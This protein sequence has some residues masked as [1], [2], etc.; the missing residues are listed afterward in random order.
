MT[1]C[2]LDARRGAHGVSPASPEADVTVPLFVDRA[3]LDAGS[4][5]RCLTS[6]LVPDDT[7]RRLAEQALTCRDRFLQL[8]A[9]P[10]DLEQDDPLAMFR[11]DDLLL[12]WREVLYGQALADA[13]QQRGWRRVLWQPAVGLGGSSIAEILAQSVEGGLGEDIHWQRLP[14]GVAEGASGARHRLGRQQR[15]GRQRLANL[16]RKVRNRCERYW[17]RPPRP[18]RCLAIFS[19]SQWQRFSSALDDL[20]SMY[21][22]D[23]S[24]WYLGRLEGP[25]VEAMAERRIALSPVPMP[26]VVDADIETFFIRRHRRWQDH[27][28]HVL[29]EEMACPSIASAALERLFATWFRFTFPRSCQWMRELK[30]AMRRCAPELVVGSAAFTSTSAMPLLAA[31]RLDIPSLAL[32]HTYICGDHSPVPARYL[33][34]RNDF[35]R[36]GFARA[37]ADDRRIIRCHNASDAMSYSPRGA[38]ATLGNTGRRRIALLTASPQ[39]RA[40][41][42]PLHPLGPWV[43][44]LATLCTPPDDLDGVEWVF[45]FHPRFDLTSHLEALAKSSN[46]VVYPAS[47]SVHE[48]LKDCWLAVLV[49][50]FGGVGVD[51]RRLGVPVIFLD[52]AGYCYPHVDPE[53]LEAPRLERPEDLWQWV[54]DLLQEPDRYA[55]LQRHN[56]SFVEGALHNAERSLLQCLQQGLAV[57]P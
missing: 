53:S 55:A 4:G 18:A 20:Q 41:A 43:D 26:P 57:T 47:A 19:T 37:F 5:E 49:N 13:V 6:E 42:M 36:Q 1:T 51:A 22:P 15:L 45:K 48:L 2:L 3:L 35:E 54:R 40:H 24:V 23:L 31:R 7:F 28:R 25:I 8:V 39:F 34:C 38:E 32:S 10:F 52:S 17:R 50:H 11:G 29:A 12:L 30:R 33:A 27:G 9:G 44:T 46:V 21:G 14:A 16:Y 56:Q